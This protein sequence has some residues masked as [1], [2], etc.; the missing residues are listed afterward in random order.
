MIRT[1]HAGRFLELV[2]DERWEFVRRRNATAVVGIVAVTP[3]DELLLV[4]QHRRPVGAAVIELPAG[5]VGD[6]DTGEDLLVAAARELI[7]ETGWEPSA[8]RILARG[9]SSAGLTSEVVT[10]VRAEGLHRVSEG[11]G[12]AGEN[13]TV[14]A[15]PLREIAAWLADRARNGVLI[16]H[17]IQAGLWWIG[18]EPAP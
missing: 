12:V 2:A 1:L 8:C 14:H 4:E 13:I 15:I 17:K 10:L 5:L 18:Q 16:D 11:G 3:A 6:D 7:E 9:P